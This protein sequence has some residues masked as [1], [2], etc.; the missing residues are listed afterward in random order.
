MGFQIII[1]SSR[2]NGI[3]DVLAIKG[4]KKTRRVKEIRCIQIKAT[5]SS[6]PIKSIFSK[7][8]RGD[9]INNKCIP[10]LAKDIFYEV[11]IWRIRKGWDIYRLNWKRKEFNKLRA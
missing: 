3:F 7:K 9:I 10:V 2:S 8:E 6:F 11:W 1:R 5:N 4:N